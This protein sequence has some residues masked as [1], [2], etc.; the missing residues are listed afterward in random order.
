VI[1]CT[2]SQPAVNTSLGKQSHVYMADVSVGQQKN[3]VTCSLLCVAAPGTGFGDRL[4]RG[5]RSARP[6]QHPPAPYL[7]PLEIREHGLGF[8]WCADAR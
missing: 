5:K 3:K 2:T 8:T 1:T 7:C 4:L 6:H